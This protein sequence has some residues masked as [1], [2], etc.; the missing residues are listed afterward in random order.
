MTYK[1]EGALQRDGGPSYRK[2]LTQ[3]N[4]TKQHDNVNTLLGLSK[5]IERKIMKVRV[6]EAK[7]QLGSW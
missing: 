6:P 3:A 1:K 4:F 7:A 2:H 5:G